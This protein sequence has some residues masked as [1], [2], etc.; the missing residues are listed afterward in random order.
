MEEE[1]G[2]E[3]DISTKKKIDKEKGRKRGTRV[4]L[5]AEKDEKGIEEE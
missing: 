4:W 5:E 2:E 1:E 3:I